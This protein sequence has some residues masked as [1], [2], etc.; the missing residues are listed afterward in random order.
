MG[1]G[2]EAI[3]SALGRTATKIGLDFNHDG[4]ADVELT[5]SGW[6]GIAVVLALGAL[7]DRLAVP[8][9]LGALGV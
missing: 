6:R 3:R 2:L 7:L 5:L 9:L 4:I 1:N 8:Y